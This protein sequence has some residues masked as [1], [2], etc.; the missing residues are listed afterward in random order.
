MST[1]TSEEPTTEEREVIDNR[2]HKPEI[3]PATK[4][5]P[6]PES[7]EARNILKAI[8]GLS[9]LAKINV[10]NADRKEREALVNKTSLDESKVRQ[11]KKLLHK[12]AIPR[13]ERPE[14]IKAIFYDNDIKSEK[15]GF[16]L[17]EMAKAWLEYYGL[18]DSIT[19]EKMKSRIYKWIH[20]ANEEHGARIHG[21]PVA[22]RKTVYHINTKPR[23]TNA[24][25]GL[26]QQFED[27]FKSAKEKRLAEGQII[28][29]EQQE[30]RIIIDNSGQVVE[31]TQHSE[32]E[33]EQELPAEP[34]Q[35]DRSAVRTSKQIENGD[36][37]Q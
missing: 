18:E 31:Q 21:T 22:N 35:L 33:T 13:K 11:F 19:L 26:L 29:K 25:T 14:L 28:L 16:T 17:T 34:E 24:Q 4:S 27:N 36:E 12:A 6:V 32:S 7:E 37:P 8:E 3:T 1:T 23:H 20:K 10:A 9:K 15:G 2:L 30:Q 5:E